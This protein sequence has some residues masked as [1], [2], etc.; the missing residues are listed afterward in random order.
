VLLL[1]INNFFLIC[2]VPEILN[3]GVGAAHHRNVVLANTSTSMIQWPSSFFIVLGG[4]RT[5]DIKAAITGPDSRHGKPVI[6][7]SPVGRLG[8]EVQNQLLVIPSS[9]D[10]TFFSIPAIFYFSIRKPG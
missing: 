3:G 6:I 9:R 8:Q 10:N 4:E 5:D 7:G 2:R 1:E